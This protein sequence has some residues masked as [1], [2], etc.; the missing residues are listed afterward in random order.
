MCWYFTSLISGSVPAGILS[1]TTSYLV[2]FKIIAD[3]HQHISGFLYLLCLHCMGVSG[4][5]L[6]VAL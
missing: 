3:Q 2:K 1:P 5:I 6:V 4:T